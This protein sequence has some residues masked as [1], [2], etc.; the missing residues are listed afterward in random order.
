MHKSTS[1]AKDAQKFALANLR[2]NYASFAK[3]I[4][5]FEETLVDSESF[6]VLQ[7][8]NVS[9]DI[10]PSPPIPPLPSENLRHYILE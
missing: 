10:Y 3:K 9:R 2:E 1:K 8:F 6:P 5:Y 7:I 4:G